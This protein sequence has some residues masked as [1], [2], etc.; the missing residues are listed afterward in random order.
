MCT[1]GAKSNEPFGTI[2]FRTITLESDG[3]SLGKKEKQ[4]L[5][6][7]PE[8]GQSSIR[9]VSHHRDDYHPLAGLV[10]VIRS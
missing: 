8:M 9:D 7:L 3:G 6:D 10:L 1:G 2:S 4:I 5:R